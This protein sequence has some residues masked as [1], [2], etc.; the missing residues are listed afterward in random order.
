MGNITSGG[1]VYFHSKMG[2]IIRLKDCSTYTVVF[3]DGDEK[4]LKR[5]SLCIK[6]QRTWNNEIDWYNIN[7]II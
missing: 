7:Y 1:K 6:G 2:V 5:G 3:D 4:T